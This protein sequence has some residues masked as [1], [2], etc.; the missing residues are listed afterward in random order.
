MPRRDLLLPARHGR[1]LPRCRGLLLPTAATCSSPPPQ[2]AVD[3][4]EEQGGVTGGGR[5]KDGVAADDEG[6]W[7]N[8]SCLV[9]TLA[10][11]TLLC[12]RYGAVPAA[13]TEPAARA[14]EAEVFDTAVIGGGAAA[15]VDFV[16]SCSAAVNVEPSEAPPAVKADPDFK[17][18]KKEDG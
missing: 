10:G 13:D 8:V 4:L 2:P 15:S 6:K 7:K 17:P 14:I 11:D 16:K 18:Q 12:K 9:D 5:G 3:Q 1:G